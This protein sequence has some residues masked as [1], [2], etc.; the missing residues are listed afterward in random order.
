MAAPKCQYPGDR[1]DSPAGFRLDFGSLPPDLAASSGSL[2]TGSSDDPRREQF[3]SGSSTTRL[4]NWP[5]YLGLSA[6][7]NDIPG[8]VKRSAKAELDSLATALGPDIGESEIRALLAR[9]GSTARLYAAPSIEIERILGDPIRAARLKSI[10]QVAAA[11]ARPEPI[12]HPVIKDCVA[13]VDYLQNVMGQQR[14]E[15]FRVLFLDTHNRLIS[16]EVLWRGTISEVQIYPREIIRR[17]LELDSS[18]IIAAHNHP[19]NMVTPSQSDIDMTRQLL[20]ASAALD[21][22]L[23]DHFIVSSSSYHSMRFHKTI[24][25]WCGDATD[26]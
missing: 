12:A 14:V 3:R 8:D 2:A 23:H 4:W 20:K 13:L 9:F 16:D 25:P 21:I 18:A 15:T 17:A 19:S 7:R 6:V 24:Y 22:A 1:F 10:L 26:E 5:G 11:I